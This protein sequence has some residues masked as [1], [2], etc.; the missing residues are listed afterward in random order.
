MLCELLRLARKQGWCSPSKGRRPGRA[1]WKPGW[2]WG[3]PNR[4]I[5]GCCSANSCSSWAAR[6]PSRKRPSNTPSPSRFLRRRGKQSRRRQSPRHRRRRPSWCRPTTSIFSGELKNCRFDDLRAFLDLHDRPVIDFATSNASISFPRA[7]CN[8]I[9]PFKRQGKEVLI[10][11]PHHLVA[12]LMG[13]VDLQKRCPH[14]RSQIPGNS[15]EQ[16]HGTTILS[17]RRAPASPW[18]ATARS[19]SGNIVIKPAPKG[20]APLPESASWP[21]LLAARRCLHLFERFEETRKHQG[22][23]LRSAVELAKDWRTDRILR[24]LEA[25]LAVADKEVSLVITGNGDVL[26]PEQGIVAIGSAAPTP[27]GAARA[28]LENRPRSRRDRH[29]NRWKSPEIFASTPTATSPSRCW[30]DR[31]DPQEIVHELD[32][33]IVGQGRGQEGGG[34]RPAQPLASRPG[35]RAAAAEITPRTS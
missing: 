27:R 18:A 1:G 5:A 24:R 15:M 26:E 22:N 34:H 17:V 7:C 31:D 30:N 9:E 4:P 20:A 16:Y 21:V 2:S 33:H 3:R 25:M 10:R 23:L 32:K 13:I 35:S 6:I 8:I 14:H 19:P 29:K 11:N 12:E 28:L